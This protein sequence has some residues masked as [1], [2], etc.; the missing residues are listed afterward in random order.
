MA[1][2]RLSTRARADLSTIGR[3]TKKQSG[4]DQT[5]RYLLALEDC[6]ALLANNPLLGRIFNPKKPVERRMEQGSHVVFYR[7]ENAGIFVRRI[8]HKGVLPERR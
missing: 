1:S 2:F 6:F 7:Q 5:E 4:A 8:L 3:Y